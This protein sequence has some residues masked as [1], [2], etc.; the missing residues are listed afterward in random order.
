MAA[1]FTMG[2]DRLAGEALAAFTSGCTPK[3]DQGQ[4]Q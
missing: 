4:L 2:V 1:A 3:S